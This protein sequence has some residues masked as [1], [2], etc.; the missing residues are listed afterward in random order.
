[1]HRV[2]LRKNTYFPKNVT[3]S[4]ISTLTEQPDLSPGKPKE[5][6]GIQRVN[7]LDIQML[8]K[9]L[10]EQVFKGKVGEKSYND[11]HIMT[12][13]E[14]LR[15]HNLLKGGNESGRVADV[16]VK[17]P[18]L[19]KNDLAKHFNIIAQVQG[20]AYLD[21]AFDLCKSETPP[22]PLT[23]SKRPGWTK[24]D[25][26]TGVAV[27]VECPMA[28]VL[29]FD[30]ETCVTDKQRPIMAVALG[31]SCWYSWASGQVTRPQPLLE[32]EDVSLD[33]LIPLEPA[34][35]AVAGSECESSSSRCRLVVGHH[36]GFDRSRIK[37]QYYMNV[38]L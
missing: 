9:P 21:L 13:K 12:S 24:Y 20:Q 25:V 15:K 18:P 7:E 16:D 5:D 28:D 35:K 19:Y 4:S 14:H 31:T 22:M 34:S 3:G 30:V 1:M 36:V 2:A 29:V 6:D 27:K 23:W 11:T 17:L 38:S 33:D 10:Y 32:D 37:E 26:K 8:S